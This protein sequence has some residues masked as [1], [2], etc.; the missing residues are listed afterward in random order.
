MSFGAHPVV[1]ARVAAAG[2]G[3]GATL[4][5]PHL[6]HDLLGLP[7]PRKENHFSAV[8]CNHV[9]A[10]PEAPCDSLGLQRLPEAPKHQVS[11]ALGDTAGSWQLQRGVSQPI[12]EQ[13]DRSVLHLQE[14]RVPLA[15]AHKP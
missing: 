1:E 11:S 2:T 10:A 7:F 4:L 8:D 9:Q 6:L 13:A 14:H 12:D 15:V 5:Y 3:G